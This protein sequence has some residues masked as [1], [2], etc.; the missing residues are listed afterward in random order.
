MVLSMVMPT[1]ALSRVALT[2]HKTTL[3]GV[4][5]NCCI[6][7]AVIW[8]TMLCCADKESVFYNKCNGF[9]VLPKPYYVVMVVV[10]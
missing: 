6:C 8:S 4:K 5:I 1:D 2:P 7:C 3:M 9:R 10:K